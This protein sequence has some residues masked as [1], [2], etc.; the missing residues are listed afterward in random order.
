MANIM[1]LVWKN[2]EGT[3]EPEVEVRI[4]SNLVKWLPR[5]MMFVPKKTKEET[6]GED[7]DFGAMATD[8]DKLVQESIA[9]GP[10]EPMTVK[11]KDSFVKISIEK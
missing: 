7:I 5:M 10:M 9:S 4:P 1:I 8:I 2:R 11:T 6:W 3:G